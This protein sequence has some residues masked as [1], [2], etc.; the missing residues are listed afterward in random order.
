MALELPKW[1]NNLSLKGLWLDEMKKTFP[2]T[3][4]H[5]IFETNSSFDVKYHTTKKS[6]IAIF[7]TFCTSINKT[8]IFSGLFIFSTFIM[9]SQHFPNIS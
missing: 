1:L 4:S 7:R 2:D 8:F 3:M 5:K 9:K 6:L